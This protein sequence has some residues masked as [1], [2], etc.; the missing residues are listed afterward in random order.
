MSKNTEE[1]RR[2]P[3]DSP[4]DASGRQLFAEEHRVLGLQP[5][6][7]KVLGGLALSGGGI[8][9]ATFNLGV[10]QGLEKAGVLRGF[11]YVSTVSG[12]GYIGGFWSAWR[13]VQQ[14]PTTASAPTDAPPAF[15][16][17]DSREISHLRSF[18]NFLRPRLPLISFETGR[19]V[20]AVA[21]ATVPS[22]VVT[23]GVLSAVLLLWLGTTWLVMDLP[24]RWATGAFLALLT[25]G[26]LAFWG[27]W[28]TTAER[29]SRGARVW[30]GFFF[31]LWRVIAVGV[32]TAL[33]W[34]AWWRVPHPLLPRILPVTADHLA[35]GYFYGAFLLPVP[36]LGGAAVLILLRTV[37]SRL[38]RTVARRRCLHGP[39]DSALAATL[40]MAVGAALFGL[41][42]VGG[43]WLAAANGP[44]GIVTALS[45]SSVAGGAFAWLRKFL[46][47]QPNRPEGGR[48]RGT[49]G[50]WLL[51]ALAYLTIAAAFLAVAAALSKIATLGPVALTVAVGGT[52]VLCALPI[53]FDPEEVGFH[54]F[55]RARLA[56]SYLG[57]ATARNSHASQEVADDDFPLSGLPLVQ[58][59]HLICCAANNLAGD[60][61][62]SLH[63]GADSAVLSGLGIQVGTHWADWRER[64][65]PSL[66]AAMTASAA[67]F[68]SHMG[69]R[70]MRLGQ[71]V[72]FLLTALNLRLGLWVDN[73]KA[74]APG[75][76]WL[77]AFYREMFGQTRL[78]AP[79]IHLSDGAH[80]ENLGLYELVR[81]GCRFIVVC[82]CGADPDYAFDDLGNAI[83]RIR[84][85]LG[86]EIDI[87]PSPIQPG[88]EGRS[89]QAA[90]VGGIR[91]GTEE[92]GVLLLIKPALQGD[93]PA[94]VRQ[95]GRRSAEFPQ[96]TTLDQFYDEAQWEAYR[97]LGEHITSGL[98]ERLDRSVSSQDNSSDKLRWTLAQARIDLKPRRDVAQ[99]V[100]LQLEQAWQA[101]E[102]DLLT[103]WGATPLAEQV[104]GTGVLPPTLREAILEEDD[105][106]GITDTLSILKRALHLMESVCDTYRLNRGTAAAGLICWEN[107]IGR[108]A[109]APL[110][111][112][113]WPW[114]APLYSRD[115]TEYLQD[116][117]TLPSWRARQKDENC[118][119]HANL[120]ET[121]EELDSAHGYARV[122]WKV[123]Y[124]DEPK[125]EG[126]TGFC[127]YVEI[128]GAK[129]M[130]AL[131]WVKLDR[132]HRTNRAICFLRDFFIPAGLWG[133]GI[134]ER[135]MRS[136]VAYLQKT[137]PSMHT[138][139]AFDLETRVSP[140][141]VALCAGPE[142]TLRKM[143]T[144]EEEQL[145]ARSR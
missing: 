82:D 132:T 74:G 106:T 128:A 107:R 13:R 121:I 68:N 131:A 9:S 115:L 101:L 60:P 127:Y 16:A 83:R 105:H 18:A 7:A 10:L 88:P 103:I 97:R 4:S 55:Y 43:Q 58:P 67:A 69:A 125:G 21:A 94:D 126:I 140:A 65:A 104:L 99:D 72:T 116:N 91:Y 34:I 39:L 108:W 30:R 5:N 1:D 59:L 38:C 84:T 11:H 56:R 102:T 80:F 141:V 76:A 62:P 49:A 20:A 85:D 24:Q 17:S 22:L 112:A 96:Q 86:V 110:F 35:E 144:T 25:L 2:R 129:V 71:G 45:A 3:R 135:F 81:R 118:S 122:R 23:L 8:R 50:P 12:G 57:A 138:E 28:R 117:F 27:L 15:P 6:D 77:P 114:L 75:R 51:Q 143:T 31:V 36:I 26:H 87:D 78:T 95:Y 120:K 137:H 98:L 134:S 109:T 40:Y 79:R 90:V 47:R 145:K 19:M 42:W 119:Y 142:I 29:E 32:A 130:I 53:F 33:W 136:F 89:P 93:E 124:G 123:E 133:S 73:P 139:I 54:S 63:R 52:L 92:P 113:W 44:R 100:R 48:V 37:T 111:G 66:G 14:T 64:P 70:S 46:G 61:I 41:L